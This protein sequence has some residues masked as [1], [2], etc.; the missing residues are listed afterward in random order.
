MI[1][2]IEVLEHVVDPVDALRQIAR[3]LKPGGVLFLTTGNARPFR[4][5]LSQWRYVIPEIHVSFFEP[6]T[7]GLAMQTAG[8]DPVYPRFRRRFRSDHPVQDPQGARRPA[9]RA[10]GAA[11]PW[12]I[13]SRLVDCA[14]GALRPSGRTP[15]G[16]AGA[17]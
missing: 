4:N 1:T 12:S 8:L 13:V 6:Q 2:A 3:L 11:V 15:R 17:A 5:R 10:V 7:L 16:C 14:A 9:A